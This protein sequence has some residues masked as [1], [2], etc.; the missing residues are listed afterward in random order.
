[1]IY[2]TNHSVDT[3]YE[4]TVHYSN[5]DKIKQHNKK[6]ILDIHHKKADPNFEYKDEDDIPKDNPREMVVASGIIIGPTGAPVKFRREVAADQRHHVDAEY[7]T[8]FCNT[9]ISVFN[10]QTKLWDVSTSLNIAI[11]YLLQI[12]IVMAHYSNYATGVCTAKDYNYYV[13]YCKAFERALLGNNGSDK[14]YANDLFKIITDV[15][16]GTGEHTYSFDAPGCNVD[17]Y[18]ALE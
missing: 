10:E 3:H 8:I 1:M 9:K 2:C 4:H 14:R 7:Q 18:I 17:C 15:S 6:V 11:T 5:V 13:P 16:G 12:Q